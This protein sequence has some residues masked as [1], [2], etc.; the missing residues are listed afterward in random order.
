MCG[1][2]EQTPFMFKNDLATF[3]WF[4]P[5]ISQSSFYS[6]II[7]RSRTSLESFRI[8]SISEDGFHCQLKHVH[9]MQPINLNNFLQKSKN[10]YKLM[11]I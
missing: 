8:Q 6:Q 9:E 5:M 2:T 1:A 7:L 4:V 11:M 10:K 3:K